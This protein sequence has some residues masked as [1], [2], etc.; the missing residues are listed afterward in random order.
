MPIRLP[1]EPRALIAMG[2]PLVS[3]PHGPPRTH[4]RTHGLMRYLFQSF[5][6]IMTCKGWPR[7][8]K[9]KV[10]KRR[11]HRSTMDKMIVVRAKG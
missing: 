10:E 4:I 11:R 3:A 9:K 2:N 5:D 7:E 1:G 6:Y 8:G